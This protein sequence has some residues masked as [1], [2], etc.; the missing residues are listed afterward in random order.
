MVRMA[1]VTDSEANWISRLIFQGIRRRAGR[2]SETWRIAAHAPGLL[3]GWV[4]HELAL[5][6]S[7]RIERRLRT[8]AQIKAAVLIGCP[9]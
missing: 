8:L 5:E 1:G 6:R 9:G 4:L 7:R 2:L 3:V